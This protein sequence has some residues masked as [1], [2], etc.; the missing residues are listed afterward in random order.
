MDLA[1]RNLLASASKPIVM[2]NPRTSSIIRRMA[3]DEKSG[4]SPDSLDKWEVQLRKGSWELAVLAVIGP[5]SRYGL[6]IMNELA[7]SGLDVPEGTLYPLLNRMR[8]AGWLTAEW[9]ESEGGHPRK[10]YRVT[11]V[12]RRQLVGRA[13]A[14]ARFSAGL[15]ALLRS[16]LKENP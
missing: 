10:Y 6:E 11:P 13:R 12:G 15:D 16:V 14:W 4:S 1:L 5:R 7:E 3:R 8:N 2:K 9:V